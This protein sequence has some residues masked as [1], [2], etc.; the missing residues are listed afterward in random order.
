MRTPAGAEGEV[1]RGDLRKMMFVF[2]LSSIAFA[3]GTFL[4]GVLLFRSYEE[5]ADLRRQIRVQD[6]DYELASRNTQK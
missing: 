6:G 5:N 1:T 3:L 2:F 4:T